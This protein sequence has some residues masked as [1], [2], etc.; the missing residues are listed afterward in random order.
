MS[1]ELELLKQRITEL[2]AENAELRKEN[3]EICNLRFKLSVFDAE[4]AE[5]KRRNVM[6]L[7]SNAEYNE[8]RDAENAK[9]RAEIE[10]LKKNNFKENAELRDRVTKDKKIV[11]EDIRR[12]NKEKKLQRELAGQDSS[13][14]TAY[15]S[16]TVNNIEKTNV[17]KITNCT[18]SELSHEI[19]V[20]EDIA[21]SAM[22]SKTINDRS[23]LENSEGIGN[24]VNIVNNRSVSEKLEE[25]GKTVN[26][27]NDQDK[28]A[29]EPNII[30]EFVQ[31]LLE[32]LLSDNDQ[33]HTIKFYSPRTL[34]PGSISIKKLA[35]SFYQAN[36]ARNKMIVV[37]RSEIT[38]WC[39]FSEKFEDKVVELRSEDKKLADRTARSQ[40][41]AEMKP[42]L[43]GIS[44]GYLR[45]MTCKARK[46][47]KLFGYKYDSVSLKKIDGIPGYMVNRVTCSANKISRLT[48]P[49]ID[50]IIE[51]VKLK[52]ITSHVSENSETSEKSLPI[53][54]ENSL[55]SSISADEE[56]YLKMLTGSLDDE[57]ANRDIPYKNSARVEKEEVNE[58][59]ESPRVQSDDDV[60]FG[61]EVDHDSAPHPV[62]ETNDDD[63]SHDNDSEEEM[64]EDSDDD[65]YNDYGGYNEYGECDR[66]YYYHDGGYERKTSPMISPIISPVTAC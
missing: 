66:G 18:S 5:L 42:Y 41:Y 44:D 61:E 62:E 12:R 32:E 54:E 56:D 33:L 46:I 9:L 19:G 13:S 24:S 14:D 34:V 29:V 16:G 39:L 30:T 38:L 15:E 17:P 60:Y 28:T 25:F 36:V 6:T 4:I 37:K 23:A 27:D 48:N 2:E 7:R 35:N 59:K 55:T 3:T 8:R 20:I 58:V 45:T 40:I 64:L 26:Q 49:Q 52:T 53:P 31:G 43:T 1:S 51:Q 63:C 22:D 21:N 57:T 10:E 47:N 50:Y 65:G 11:G